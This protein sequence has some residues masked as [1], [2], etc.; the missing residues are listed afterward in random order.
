MVSRTKKNELLTDPAEINPKLLE[1]RSGGTTKLVSENTNKNEPNT[2][3]PRG[4]YPP[5]SNIKG[6]VC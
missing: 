6:G 5:I 4:I 2:A 3:E 1:K